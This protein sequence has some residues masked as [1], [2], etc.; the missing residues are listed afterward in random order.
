MLSNSSGRFKG[1][2]K[3]PLK[4][5]PDYLIVTDY[6]SKSAYIELGMEENKVFVC[7]HPQENRIKDFKKILENKFPRNI[8]MLKRWLFISEGVDL[9]RPSESFKSRD[10]TLNE[11]VIVVG[12]LNSFRRN[13][14]CTKG[15]IS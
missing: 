7:R 9:L 13:N 6:Y 2:S 15:S 1:K 11:E 5:K 14:R 3:D 10:Y 4:H 8:A 12:E